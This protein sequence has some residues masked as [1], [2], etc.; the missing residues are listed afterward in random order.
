MDRFGL[1]G[2]P[3]AHS[4]SPE[5]F[6]KAYGGR[7]EYDLIEEEDFDRAWE[8][9]CEGP[10]RA[11]NVTAPFKTPAALKADIKS[12]E[13]L[14]TGAA[15][16]L[17]RTEDGVKAFNSDYLGLLGLLPEGCGKT[18]AVIGLGGAGRA[19]AAAAR[20]KGFTVSTF[21]HGEISGGVESDL[22]IYTLPC[23]VS[24]ADRLRSRILVEAN[25]KDPCL[26]DHEGY[27]P[28]TDWLKAQADAGFFIMTGEKPE[29]FFILQNI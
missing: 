3:I 14:K 6:R 4:L 26:A 1:I 16:I 12:P 25:Y 10:Y 24:G 15:N 2:C 19:A 13:V 20:D 5:L 23:F 27:I 8:R 28:G 7:W 11:V 9:F 17:L 22:I 21:H 29:N 18:A